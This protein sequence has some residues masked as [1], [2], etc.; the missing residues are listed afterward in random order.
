MLRPVDY[1]RQKL[2]EEKKRI[3][4]YAQ[5]DCEFSADATGLWQKMEHEWQC[6]EKARRLKEIRRALQRLEEGVYGVCERCGRPINPER[7]EILPWSTLCVKCKN[8]EESHSN[9]Y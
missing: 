8:Y 3:E 9:Q 5:R 6:R 1:Y 2:E 4:T 7:L